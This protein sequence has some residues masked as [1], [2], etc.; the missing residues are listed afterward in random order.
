MC[1]LLRLRVC[2]SIRRNIGIIYCFRVPN[3]TTATKTLNQV[4]TESDIQLFLL[5]A[6]VM[7][8]QFTEH[9]SC[10]HLQVFNK[11]MKHGT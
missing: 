1:P 2:T 4:N 9:R 8:A 11:P 3:L 7:H 6:V 10:A 5:Q